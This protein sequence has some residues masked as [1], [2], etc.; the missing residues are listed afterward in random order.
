MFSDISQQTLDLIAKIGG[1]GSLN[2]TTIT[3]GTS[4]NQFDLRGP[5]LNLFP[6]LTPLRNT[7]P[8]ELS[9]Q[10]DVATRWKAIVGI[11]TT[12]LTPGVQE[13]KRGAEVQ[14]TEQDFLATYA[15]LGYEASINWEAVWSGGNMFDNRAT[16]AHSL[17]SSAMISEEGVIL[18][19]NNSLALGTPATPVLAGPTAG[20]TITAQ[21]GNV[22]FVVA[23]T[24]EGLR[25]ATGNINGLGLQPVLSGT[26]VKGSV[27]RTNIDAS[28]TTH[29]GGSS[30][31]SASS[32][33]I[34]TTGGNQTLTA[35]V[36]DVR[37]AAAYAWF[38]GTSSANA[39]LAAITTTNSVTLTA[40]GVGAQVASAISADNSQNATEFDGFLTLA[41]KTANNAYYKSLDGTPLTADNANGINEIDAALQSLWD[42]ARVGP[43]EIWT[44][45]QEQRNITKKIVN[46]GTSSIQRV[47]S[48]QNDSLIAGG[49]GVTKYFNKFTNSDVELRIHPAIPAGTIFLKTNNIPYPLAEVGTVNLI[50]CRRDYYQ[51]EW[52]WTTRQYVSGVYMDEVLV[53]RAPFTL[54]IVKNVANG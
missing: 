12:N 22:V 44:H 3:Q 38:L 42:N 51:I 21:A 28:T 2:K 53:A 1:P 25:L 8:R 30:N 17:L 14:I 24:W 6:V 26:T 47:T 13:G 41:S 36:A 49:K 37:G 43:D 34:T 29:G 10:G 4:L 27:T 7:L 40:N 19:G 23:L 35:T 45:S 54:G 50:R 31:L 16:L 48:G 15:G 9:Q 46:A 39:A 11:N 32:N 20:G 52:P 33:A 5:A 18:A